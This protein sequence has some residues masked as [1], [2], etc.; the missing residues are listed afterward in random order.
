MMFRTELTIHSSSERINHGSKIMTIGSC[1]SQ[2]IGE[3]LSQ[4]KFDA[5][6]NPFGTVFNPISIFKL[7]ENST[8]NNF[9]ML[10][11]SVENK[12]TWF[13]YHVH[14]DVY[15]NTKEELNSKLEEKIKYVNEF[16]LQTDTLIITFGTAFVYKLK[17]NNEI[18]ANCHKQPAANFTKELLTVEEIVTSF[19]SF[20]N[21]FKTKNS[22]LK[23]ILTVSPVRHTKD[24]LTL[25][26]V[27]KS[28]LR[29]ACHELSKR[30]SNVIYFPSYEIML[31]D[32]RDYRFY[33][34]DMIHPTEVAE[35]YIWNKFSDVYFENETKQLIKEWS[36][37]SM[38]LNHKPFR[39]DSEE[40]KKFL[41]E[42]LRKLES[43]NKKINV[44]EE[45]EFILGR[46]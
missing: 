7:L 12:N 46:I 43:L 11:A 41:A 40:Y 34:E 44:R 23:I 8:S 38:A 36:S 16:L 14:S 10:D 17:S 33:K 6:V 9:S 35:E 4:N 32:L 13:N 21:Q 2:V 20:L 31:D 39:K 29:I 5:L 37:V 42:T 3:R 15:G 28:I 19:E 1:F 25:N 26:S 27:S 18:V 30:F 22:K 24:S 45:I